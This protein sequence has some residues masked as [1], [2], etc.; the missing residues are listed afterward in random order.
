MLGLAANQHRYRFDDRPGNAATC[1]V[2]ATSG[3]LRHW[4]FTAN[5]RDSAAPACYARAMTIYLHEGDLPHD[6]FAPGP[7]A[8]DSETMGL[9]PHRDRLCLVQLA[10]GQ[11]D[12]HLVRFAK[13]QYDAPVLKAV[14]ADPARHQAVSFRPLRPCRHQAVSRRRCDAGVLHQDRVETGAHLYRSPRPEGRAARNRRGRYLQGAA[15]VGLGR[16]RA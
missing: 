4:R 5:R 1:R 8:V 13:G 16:R 9:H 7:I 2:T 12:E 11:G 6:V 15:I 14:L 10:D 3:R